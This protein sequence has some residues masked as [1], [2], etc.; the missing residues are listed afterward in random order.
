M[1]NGK[2]GDSFE[3]TG[4]QGGTLGLRFG[5]GHGAY[6]VSPSWKAIQLELDG[7]FHIFD[8]TSAFWRKCPEV[9]GE[10]IKRWFHRH[11]LYPW[12]PWQTPKVTMVYLGGNK[13]RALP[14]GQA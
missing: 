8:I 14:P 12:P 4:W 2:P 7:E 3:A 6:F 11:G 5:S 10:P 13:F 9:R 1:P